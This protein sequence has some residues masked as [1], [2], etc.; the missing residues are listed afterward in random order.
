MHGMTCDPLSMQARVI[1]LWD[2]SDRV[3]DRERASALNEK[4]AFDVTR[5]SLAGTPLGLMGLL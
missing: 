1:V 3:H 4:N 5:L 2:Q